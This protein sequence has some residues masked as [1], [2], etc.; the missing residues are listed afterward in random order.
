MANS[1][2]IE[3]PPEDTLGDQGLRGSP[4]VLAGASA[5][6]QLSAAEWHKLVSRVAYGIYL[7]RGQSPGHEI[8]DWLA[9]ERMLFS[10]FALDEAED[11]DG[12]DG[13]IT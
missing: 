6:S 5:P 4:L 1:N 7:S 11:G 12:F 13:K 10:Q 8:E 2:E 3:Y 9:A